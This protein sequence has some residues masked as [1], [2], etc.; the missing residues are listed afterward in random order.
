MRI[1]GSSSSTRAM[2]MIS[3][4]VPRSSTASRMLSRAASLM[5][6]TLM[7]TRTMMVTAP[8]MVLYGHSRRIGQKMERYCGTNRAEMAMVAV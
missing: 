1:L 6:T 7:T 3:T 4:C 2:I 5:P 8:P